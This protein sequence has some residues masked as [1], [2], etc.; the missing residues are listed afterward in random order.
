MRIIRAAQPL[1]LTQL[2][3][4]PFASRRVLALFCRAGRCCQWRVLERFAPG[5]LLAWLGVFSIVGH[6]DAAC[7]SLDAVRKIHRSRNALAAVILH[8]EILC[9]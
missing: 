5:H 3:T 9:T 7:T 6:V 1:N 8:F 2:V 4:G